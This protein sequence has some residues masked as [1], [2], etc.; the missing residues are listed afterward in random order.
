MIIINNKTN[1]AYEEKTVFEALDEDLRVE[2]TATA[3]GW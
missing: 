3:A 2:T 1:Q